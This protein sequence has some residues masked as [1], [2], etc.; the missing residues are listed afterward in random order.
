MDWSTAMACGAAGGLVVELVVV[1]GSLTDW[2]AARR[3]VRRVR[4]Q[5]RMPSLTDYLDPLA[6]S[7]VA[8]T[9]VLLGAVAGVAFHTQVTGA[10]AAI[11]V[12]AAAPALLGQLATVRT[13]RDAVAGESSTE[14][15]VTSVQRRHTN[16]PG[17]EVPEREQ[18][19]A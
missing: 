12:G 8:V 10:A 11:A 15:V 18:A 17:R 7:L 19:K 5:R 13:L 9:R 16:R 4:R 1:F 6:D 14:A 2:Q 3:R